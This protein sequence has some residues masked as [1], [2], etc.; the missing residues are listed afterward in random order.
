MQLSARIEA[1][2]QARLMEAHQRRKRVGSGRGSQRMLQK[3][4]RKPHG[5]TAEFGANCR[6][7]ARAVI[8]LIEWEIEGA[9]DDREASRELGRSLRV[10]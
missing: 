3:Q 10:K 2:R 7:G 6:F 9:L 4:R 5:L 8:A 1:G